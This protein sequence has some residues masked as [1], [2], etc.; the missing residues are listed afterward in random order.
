MATTLAYRHFLFLNSTSPEKFSRRK[1]AATSRKP[2]RRFDLDTEPGT[3]ELQHRHTQSVN[4][5]PSRNLPNNPFLTRALI[6]AVV[7]GSMEGAH[8]LFEKMHHWD[9]FIWNV[10]IRGYTDRG[11]FQEAV[12][13]YERMEDE[14]VPMDNLT[15]TFVIKACGGLLALTQGEKIHGKLF[16]VGLDVDVYIC[17]ALVSMYGK[18][19]LVDL[20]WKVFE[21]MPVRDLVSWN[22]M[23]GAYSLVKEHLKS[24][25]CFREMLEIGIQPDKFTIMNVL[26]ACSL[27]D[28]LFWGKETHCVALKF[29][30]D[31]DVMVQTL[32][33][34]MYSKCG[35]LNYAERVFG[36]ISLTNVVAWNAMIGGYAQN[37][38]PLQALRSLKKMLKSENVKVDRI[39]LINLLPSCAQLGAVL[40]GVGD[41][42]TARE[43][44]DRTT[45]KDI[46][47][48][49]TMMMA[50]AIH[51]MG[52]ISIELFS[53]MKR[54]GI[55]PN[56]STFV[57]LLSS[58]SN[59]GMVNEGWMYYNSMKLDYG[60]EP[61]IEHYGCMLDLIGRTGELDRAMS[62][63]EEMPVPPTARI[64]GSLLN[65][66]RKKRNIELAELA[67]QNILSIDHDNTGCYI[68][69]SNMYAEA[70]RWEKVEHIKSIMKKA[71]SDKTV[72]CSIIETKLGL[73]RFTNDDRSHVDSEMIYNV[74]DIVSRKT[75]DKNCI[76]SNLTKFKPS[77]LARKR[78]NLP[79]NHSVRLAI[80][81]GLISTAI[82]NPVLVRKNMRICEDCH[83]AVKKISE[84]SRREIIVGDSKVFH[85]FRDGNC[86]CGDYW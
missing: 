50:Y 22:S 65:A 17:N 13:L 40:P 53:E 71:G 86:S 3:S 81:F 35:S 38:E 66:S 60:I 75:G 82:G 2:R 33:I 32:L 49:N 61:K 31:S 19:G 16:K 26:D 68:L 57:S 27:G 67:A 23:M 30:F 18:F 1:P 73:H 84:M 76:I 43:I 69:L 8:N 79:E 63:I 25:K 45:F 78:A 70:G 56:D 41:I 62:F 72:A 20:A 10:M 55:K 58:C 85:H 77:D 36:R 37:G 54:Q 59:S 47:S 14:G 46:V 9:T 15:Y 4:P 48:W 5:K 29:G 52:K 42:K 21:E 28:S 39:T 64:W 83:I 44:F 34:D 12:N 7:S 51:G 11:L 74:R 80:C 24:L 6:D